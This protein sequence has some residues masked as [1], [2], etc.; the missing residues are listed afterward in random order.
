MTTVASIGKIL[1]Q[2]M[3]STFTWFD[4][5]LYSPRSKKDEKIYKMDSSVGDLRVNF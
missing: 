2:V 3:P 4:E 5:A 1:S